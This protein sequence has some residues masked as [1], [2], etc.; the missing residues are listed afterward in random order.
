MVLRLAL[1]LLGIAEVVW[2]RRTVDFWM[3]LAAKGDEAVELESWV[4][5]VA[6]L[7]GIL[8]L[9]WVFAAARRE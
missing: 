9:L 4:Y 5:T 1:G 2:P 6:R 7:E 3:N 8:I